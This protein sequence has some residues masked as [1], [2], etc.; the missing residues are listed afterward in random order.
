LGIAQ[1]YVRCPSLSPL[2]GTKTTFHTRV[3]RKIVADAL[4]APARI[5]PARADVLQRTSKRF[6]WLMPQQLASIGVIRFS[7]PWT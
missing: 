7:D 2:F 4:P 5:P 3:I 1:Y 6:A